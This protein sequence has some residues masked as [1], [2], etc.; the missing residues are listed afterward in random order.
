MNKIMPRSLAQNALLNT[1][2]GLWREEHL[3]NDYE[4]ASGINPGCFGLV[5][6]DRL[7]AKFLVALAE[8][9]MSTGMDEAMW[10]TTLADSVSSNSM[11]LDTIY[12]FPGI[13]LS[14]K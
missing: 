8:L 12:Y 4:W 14:E 5:G 2:I 6:N 9:E 3:N 1:G 11:G 10:A 7:F 13:R